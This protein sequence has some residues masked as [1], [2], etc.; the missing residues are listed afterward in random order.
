MQVLE[1][2]FTY[3]FP[4]NTPAVTTLTLASPICPVEMM[5]NVELVVT[6]DLSKVLVIL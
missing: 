3:L 5:R 6:Y 1:V 2:L 4:E